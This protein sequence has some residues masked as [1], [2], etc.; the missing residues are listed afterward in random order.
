MKF[1]RLKQV[2]DM[3]GLSRSSIYRHGP[4][5]RRVGP[6]AVGWL[7]LRPDCAGLGARSCQR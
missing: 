4:P 7:E 1:L 3:T 2:I 6:N 5:R